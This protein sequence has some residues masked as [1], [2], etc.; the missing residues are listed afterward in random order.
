[1]PLS[2]I[3]STAVG[4]FVGALIVPY[5]DVFSALVSGYAVAFLCFVTLFGLSRFHFLKSAAGPVQTLV[6][7][8]V[9][10]LASSVT[11]CFFMGKGIASLRGELD[12][13]RSAPA[14]ESSR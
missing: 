11:M 5:F 13:Y 6:C 2:I 12:A 7:V 10:M 9:C 4:F 3:I 1:M 8:L 14:V